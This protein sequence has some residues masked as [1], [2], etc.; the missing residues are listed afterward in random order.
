MQTRYSANPCRASLAR[1]PLLSL[2]PQDA[3]NR[4]LELP[5]TLPKCLKLEDRI[6]IV[7]S[8]FVL[9]VDLVS[10]SLDSRLPDVKQLHHT[11]YAQ[12]HKGLTTSSSSLVDRWLQSISACCHTWRDGV[13]LVQGCDARSTAH[14]PPRLAKC[15][16]PRL[17]TCLSRAWPCHRHLPI[18]TGPYRDCTLW[19]IAIVT[20][21]RPLQGCC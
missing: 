4:S 12:K 16:Q 3:W 11:S 7:L 5:P 9:H 20:I 17:L 15:T 10:R 6:S 19:L 14:Q 18:T 21:G 13:D 1:L 2:C 8:S